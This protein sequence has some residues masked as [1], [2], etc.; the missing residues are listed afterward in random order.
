M[1]GVNGTEIQFAFTFKILGLTCIPARLTGLSLTYED[2]STDSHYQ[3][4]LNQSSLA[5]RIF[6][7]RQ[8]GDWG[9]NIPILKIRLSNAETNTLILEDT[10]TTQLSGVFEYSTNNG[11]TWAAWNNTQNLVGNFIR[12]TATTL[13]GGT[14]IKATILQA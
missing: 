4:S 3:P 10:T 6:A 9:G 13:P 12:Y 1:S 14:K 2:L 5:S 7:Y 8:S 11:V